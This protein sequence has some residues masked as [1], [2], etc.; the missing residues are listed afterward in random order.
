MEVNLCGSGHCPKVLKVEGG[1]EVGEG[2]NLVKLKP[3]EW[4]TLVSMVE[5]GVL[6]K[7]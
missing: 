1:V 2:E 3:E 7:V 5:K 4:N 6:H